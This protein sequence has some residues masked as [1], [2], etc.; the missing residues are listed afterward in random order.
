MGDRSRPAWRTSGRSATG[1]GH[2]RVGRAAPGRGGSHTVTTSSGSPGRQRLGGQCALLVAFGV[3]G[4]P[5]PTGAADDRAVRLV[6]ARPVAAWR[7]SLSRH[8]AVRPCP[9]RTCQRPGGGRH[10][11]RR[12]DLAVRPDGLL[13]V[14]QHRGVE[15][16]DRGPRPSACPTM[17]VKVGRTRWE[18]PTEFSVVRSSSKPVVERSRADPEAYE[19]G[20]LGPTTARRARR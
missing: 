4:P 18:I 1:C 11:P 13:S 7:D 17:V 6:K 10:R 9:C 2:R 5:K 3:R 14:D 20:V 16:A 8:D 12:R 15:V 19:Q